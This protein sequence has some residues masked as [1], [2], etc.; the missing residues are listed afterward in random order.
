MDQEAWLRKYCDS[1]LICA[2]KLYWDLAGT[3]AHV[4]DQPVLLWH[5]LLQVKPE[6]LDP[7]WSLPLDDVLTFSALLQSQPLGSD[8]AALSLGFSEGQAPF[9]IED[10]FGQLLASLEIA[11]LY[12]WVGRYPPPCSLGLLHSMYGSIFWR[13]PGAATA[14]AHEHRSITPLHMLLEGLNEVRFQVP[15]RTQREQMISL[16]HDSGETGLDRDA[17]AVLQE[18]VRLCMQHNLV[19]SPI[20]LSLA[21]L[22]CPTLPYKLPSDVAEDLEREC[23]GRLPRQGLSAVKPDLLMCHDQVLLSRDSTYAQAENL[24]GRG[25]VGRWVPHPEG[26]LRVRF[27]QSLLVRVE[28]GGGTSSREVDG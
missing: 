13:R 11:L 15:Y 5:C 18:L 25:R 14:S 22:S 1:Q 16:L 17:M 3:E 10:V 2:F 6:I 23:L 28:L 27:D 4:F 9:V 21:A 8:G 26:W 19:P 7:A 24:L 20:H 12:W